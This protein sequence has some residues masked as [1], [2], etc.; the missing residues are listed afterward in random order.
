MPK[1]R[2]H[3]K[4]NTTQVH[5]AEFMAELHEKAVSRTVVTKGWGRH[6]GDTG[7]MIEK[8]I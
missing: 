2:V 8:F 1:V 7:Q 4:A 3:R 5:T 6:G